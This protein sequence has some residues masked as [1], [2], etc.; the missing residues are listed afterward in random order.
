VLLRADG[1]PVANPPIQQIGTD[2]GLMG[3]PVP[4]TA[5]GLILAPAE[6][7][8]LIVDFSGF[9]DGVD[10]TWVNVATAPYD[11]TTTA[12]A[13]P[14]QPAAD[15]RVPF[16]NVMQFRV[17]GAPSGHALALPSPLSDF[18]P[19]DHAQFGRHEHRFVALREEVGGPY[20]GL[21]TLWELEKVADGAAVPP[22]D[23]LTVDFDLHAP[24]GPAQ[25][26]RTT[27]RVLA[28]VFDDRLNFSVR[29]GAYEVWHLL[30]LTTDTHPIHLHLVQFQVTG[31]ET[32]RTL[33]ATGTPIDPQTTPVEFVGPLGIPPNE[34]AWK[35]TV[36]VNPTEKV[37]IAARFDGF[38]GRYVYH[39]HVLEHE[40]HDM[41]RPYDV[42]P[43]EVDDIMMRDMPMTQGG[44]HGH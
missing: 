13:Q 10:L 32:Y 20:D 37:T 24:P 29:L 40:D 18:A 8:D 5:D 34:V 35:D 16:P 28:R 11:N 23:S 26:A 17:R 22:G 2:G 14:G 44:G 1:Q 42:L 36:R 43:P 12:P 3:A 7:A 15:K 19:L 27:Y 9:P 39:C 4:V 6:R 31:K 25:H 21:L 30:N 33:D 41:M 38:A